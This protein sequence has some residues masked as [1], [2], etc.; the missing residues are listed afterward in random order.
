MFEP[1]KDAD[2]VDIQEGDAISESSDNEIVAHT[3]EQIQYGNQAS[4]SESNSDDGANDGPPPLNSDYDDDDDIDGPPPLD[5]DDNA[6]DTDDGE[7]LPTSPDTGSRE[8]LDSRR[9]PV[10]SERRG[11]KSSEDSESESD[12]EAGVKEAPPPLDSEDEQEEEIEASNSGVENG[13]STVVEATEGYVH[14]S[15]VEDV[16]NGEDEEH[17]NGDEEG[18]YNNYGDEEEHD[19]ND[20]QRDRENDDDDDKQC[21]YNDGDDES[22]E[23]DCDRDHREVHIEEENT[24]ATLHTTEAAAHELENSDESEQSDSP[25]EAE[26]QSPV[27]NQSSEEKDDGKESDDEAALDAVQEAYA[28]SVTNAERSSTI[29]SDENSQDDENRDDD[30]ENAARYDLDVKESA[31]VSGHDQKLSTQREEPDIDSDQ[32]SGE[33]P[34]FVPDEDE[35]ELEWDVEDFDLPK[36]KSAKP[37]ATPKIDAEGVEVDKLK[38]SF[39]DTLRSEAEHNKVIET[40]QKAES[41]KKEK[42]SKGLKTKNIHGKEEKKQVKDFSRNV[43]VQDLKSVPGSARRATKD[44]PPKTEQVKAEKKRVKDVKNVATSKPVDSTTKPV[45][46]KPKVV[47]NSLEKADKQKTERQKKHVQEKP[48]I[49]EV[50]ASEKKVASK[51][52]KA[53]STSTSSLPSGAIEQQRGQQASSTKEKKKPRPNSDFQADLHPH[54]EETNLV[55]GQK[56]KETRKPLKS[57]SDAA[58]DSLTRQKPQKTSSSE[59]VSK[60]KKSNAVVSTTHK[61][62][63]KTVE[64]A[65]TKQSKTKRTA[66]KSVAMTTDHADGHSHERK[67]HSN[68]HVPVK[69]AFEE[70]TKPRGRPTSNGHLSSSQEKLSSHSGRHD[71]GTRDHNAHKHGG[72][73]HDRGK[74]VWLCR[75]DEIHKLIAQ[76]ASLLKEYESGSLAGRKV[77]KY[78]FKK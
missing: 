16:D 70:K 29:L 24:Q 27:Q 33:S 77:C 12:S 9:P 18:H 8:E 14:D 13:E 69:N 67:R 78:L 64:G 54:K 15:R 3:K 72:H 61:E 68:V 42:L 20:D 66:P 50:Q 40:G 41:K 34:E 4:S 6:E 35:N 52:A 51:S 55:A 76:K 30:K 1:S 45:K 7:E 73:A 31:A 39:L 60:Q 63:A 49:P 25:A 38:K 58:S 59:S 62:K 26:R 19:K 47:D 44:S 65:E 10:H 74:H 43:S 75:D 32:D 5:T 11:V 36:H 23:H 56:R 22:D 46:A 57:D 48:R 2:F 17:D 53:K 37:K 71:H 21:D 28:V